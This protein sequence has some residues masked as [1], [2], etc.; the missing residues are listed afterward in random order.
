MLALLCVAFTF[1]SCSDNE[2]LPE[3]D[4]SKGSKDNPYTVAEAIDAVKDLTW[5]SNAEYDKTG[6]V[7][8]KGKISRIDNYGT[9]AENV[10]YG[11]ASFYISEDGTQ[12]NEFFCFRVL[13][14]GNKVHYFTEPGQYLFFCQSSV[15]CCVF[16]KFF[17]TAHDDLERCRS[18]Q[19]V[20][21][22][23]ELLR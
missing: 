6:D 17:Q 4:P 12:N 5:T 13:Y 8:V 16:L 23:L 14:F 19:I 1:T 7:Y 11:Y 18:F 15:K 10:P 22:L 2:I 20:F 3:D 9:F 21:A